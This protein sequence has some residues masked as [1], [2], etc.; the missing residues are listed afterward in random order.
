MYCV[1]C[2]KEIP[3]DSKVCM[4]CGRKIINSNENVH[5]EEILKEQKKF[6][7]KKRKWWKILIIILALI[8]ICLLW[9]GS[10]SDGSEKEIEDYVKSGTYK[11]YTSVSLGEVLEYNW[12]DGQWDSF[13][14]ENDGNSFQVV[15]YAADENR[16]TYVQF[17]V[18]VDEE[19]FEMV[20]M[21]KEGEEISKEDADIEMESMYYTYFNEQYPINDID[22]NNYVGKEIQELLD[23]TAAFYETD[24]ELL[25]YEDVSRNVQIM[26]DEKIPYLISIEGDGTYSPV[27]AG[28]S[29]GQN[30]S[31]LEKSKITES[32][33]TEI[34]WE[35]ESNCI[36]GNPDNKSTVT[37]VADETGKIVNI[38]WNADT[39]DEMTEAT[40][41]T[42]EEQY[43]FPD[44]DKKY[45]SE[46]E[47]RSQTV[48]EL[49]IGRNEIFARYGYI[50]EDESLQQHFGNTSWYN[51]TVTG[52]QFN[53]D[54]VFND[55]EKKNVE[56]IKR[57]EDEIN[58]PS[59]EELA[60]QAAI[61]GAYNF[62]VGKRFHLE[63]SQPMMEVQSSDTIRYCWGGN[64]EDDY[65][66]YSIT[67][68]YE[69][70][71]D[72]QKAWLT[73]I[74]IG[75]EEYYLR[76]F[77]NGKFNIACTSGIGRLDGWYEPL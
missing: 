39:L 46:D 40:N 61:D 35:D 23:D 63:N 64:I 56:L 75:G 74:T 19:N 17:A 15:E 77:E 28:N 76:C 3:D 21:K 25:V 9:I 33:Y 11:E 48:D 45:L 2:G 50:F 1:K 32:G 53:A 49:Y 22:L 73:F 29:V 12:K 26:L 18:D 66:N 42:K 58:G 60:Q 10:G 68:R 7:K 24:E 44:S 69:I 6:L 62:L 47:V 55:F 31:E 51:G 59:E 4:Y 16:S 71:R 34:V 72:D 37:Y 57:I 43:I 36:Y 8:F 52:D 30:L 14:A 20:Y 27:F 41:A 54:A 13:E 5:S 65:L 67:A 70:Y 38:I